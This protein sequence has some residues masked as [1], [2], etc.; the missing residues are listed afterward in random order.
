MIKKLVIPIILCCWNFCDA[1]V[2]QVL[3]YDEY[4]EIVKTQHPYLF[5]L[6]LLDQK[7]DAYLLK[8]KGGVDPI[9]DAGYDEKS[10]DSKNYFRQFGGKV[11]IPTWYGVEFEA[12]YEFA[13]GEFLSS[14]NSLPNNGLLNAGINIPLGNG[15]LYDER[16]KVLDEAEVIRAENNLKKIEIENKIIFAA[17]KAYLDWQISFQKVEIFAN[18]VIIAEQRLTNTKASFFEG[19]KPAI[20]TLEVNIALNS[21]QTN[22][23]LAQQELLAKRIE[24]NLYLWQEGIIPLVLDDEVEPEILGLTKWQEE[25]LALQLQDNLIDNITELQGYEVYNRQ[26]E[27]E[28]KIAK[29]NRKPTIDLTINPLFRIND[30][31]V[32]NYTFDDYKVG[33]NVYYPLFTRKAR[34]EQKIIEIEQENNRLTLITAKQSIQNERD[35]ILTELRFLEEASAILQR[36]IQDAAMLLEAENI[37]FSLG[38]SSVFLVNSREIKFLEFQEKNLKLN[39]DLFLK[40][41]ELIYL[42]QQF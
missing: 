33:A 30:P 34:G 21:R 18:A 7:S 5:Q 26:L 11:K 35:I 39:K 1:Q 36:N 22:L 8:A 15:L 14:E 31:S 27:L 6:D 13:N 23:L 28:R 25:V 40:R 3:S 16:R 12:G 38:E 42:L 17:T 9:I 24:V 20:D 29:E 10:F 4:I 2:S 19:D 41:L 37:K 32:I